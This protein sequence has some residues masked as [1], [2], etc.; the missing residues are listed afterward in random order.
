MAA[1]NTMA[2]PRAR[3]KVRVGLSTSLASVDTASQYYVFECRHGVAC[4]DRVERDVRH[5]SCVRQVNCVGE[6]H[7]AQ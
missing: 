5:T 1:T 6:R 7:H 4:G 2:S 3:G